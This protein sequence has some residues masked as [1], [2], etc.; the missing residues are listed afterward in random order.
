M[1]GM[2]Y[3]SSNSIRTG[4]TRQW[5]YIF[6]EGGHPNF[7]ISLKCLYIKVNP[8]LEPMLVGKKTMC[9]CKSL[10]PALI[11]RVDKQ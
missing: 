11:G 9:S 2:Q 6:I 3:I 7:L 8:A 4:K 5:N 1:D 10:Q